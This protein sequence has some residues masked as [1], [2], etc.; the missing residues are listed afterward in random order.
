MSK[1]IEHRIDFRDIEIKTR[2]SHPHIEQTYQFFDDLEIEHRILPYYKSV[3]NE[4]AE[5]HGLTFKELIDEYKDIYQEWL[6]SE[7]A[8]PV[9]PIKDYV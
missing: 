9:H 2:D 7:R 1:L 3:G 8:T 5:R 4:K 6:V